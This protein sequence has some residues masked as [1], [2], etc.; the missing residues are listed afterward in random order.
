M[1]NSRC[2]TLRKDQRKERELEGQRVFCLQFREQC[3]ILDEVWALGLNILGFQ[4]QVCHIL[5]L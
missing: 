5:A 3:D 2:I 1:A 4:F